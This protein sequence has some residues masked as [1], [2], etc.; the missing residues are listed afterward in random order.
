MKIQ[1]IFFA[2]VL[3]ISCRHICEKHI[4]PNNFLGQVT[5][6]FDQ[7]NAPANIDKEGCQVYIIPR[8][9]RCFSGFQFKEKNRF[10]EDQFKCYERLG[11]DSMQEI[12]VFTE[13]MYN[14]DSV[15]WKNS[16]FVFLVLSGYQ[17][18]T[19]NSPKY[20][21]QYYI[22]YGMNHMKYY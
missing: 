6:V 1:V 5:I 17:N 19:G 20:I 15:L 12:P 3:M 18:Q 7:K 8:D 22:D 13:K 9:G 14:Q 21:L 4:V 2:A 16:K 10:K 11:L